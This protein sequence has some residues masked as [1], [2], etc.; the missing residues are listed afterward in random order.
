MTFM[1]FLSTWISRSVERRYFLMLLTLCYD[2][3]CNALCY[4]DIV[5]Y[6]DTSYCYYFTLSLYGKF[7]L[8][9]TGVDPEIFPQKAKGRTEE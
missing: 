2:S 3:T 8:D 5:K 4:D 1:Q 7:T 9:A 6:G